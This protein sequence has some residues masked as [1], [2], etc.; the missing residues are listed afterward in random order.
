MSTIQM[1][2]EELEVHLGSVV[3]FMD[4]SAGREQTFTL[5]H[6]HEAQP[7]CGRLSIASPVARALLGHHVGDLVEVQTP[8]GI[9]PLVIGAIS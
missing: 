2:A 3:S 4:T 6:Q 9:R 1:T 5:V 7:A 8:R